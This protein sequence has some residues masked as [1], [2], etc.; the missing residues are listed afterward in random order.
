M[1]LQRSLFKETDDFFDS[2]E[3]DKIVEIK[4][5]KKRR[6]QCRLHNVSFSPMILRLI[7]V[8]LSSGEIEVL[9]TSLLDDER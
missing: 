3:T 7:K 9:A 4:P 8:E 5:S 2:E 1:R 6:G